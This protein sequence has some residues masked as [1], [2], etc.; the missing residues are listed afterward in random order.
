MTTQQQ[1]TQLAAGVTPDAQPAP[2]N[3]AHLQPLIAYPPL[4]QVTVPAVGTP[5]AAHYLQRADQT[6]RRW[7]AFDNGPLRPFRLNGRLMWRVSEIKALLG[8]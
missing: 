8:I 1:K 4:E 2:I 5:Q 6:L 7:A 3:S